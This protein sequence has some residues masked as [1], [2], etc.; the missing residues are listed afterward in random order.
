MRAKMRLKT[1]Q[2]FFMLI[3]LHLFLLFKQDNGLWVRYVYDWI[4]FTHFTKF[5]LTSFVQRFWLIDYEMNWNKIWISIL[6]TTIHY[7]FVT[8]YW[9]VQGEIVPNLLFSVNFF[10]WTLSSLITNIPPD[11]RCWQHKLPDYG[12]PNLQALQW[13]WAQ[14]SLQT[15]VQVLAWTLSPCRRLCCS[16]NNCN[17]RTSWCCS[18]VAS[19]LPSFSPA[20]T[21]CC[22]WTWARVNSRPNLNPQVPISRR[23]LMIPKWCRWLTVCLL[24]R[25]IYWS[26]HWW[27]RISSF[28]H[29][30]T[31]DFQ[32]P[33]CLFQLHFP[34]PHL[35]CRGTRDPRHRWYKRLIN[36]IQLLK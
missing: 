14:T 1:N 12:K 34:P 21:P 26:I 9:G 15:V 5:N 28:N 8:I 17:C 32:D 22:H 20:P 11:H 2:I 19:T 6:T 13:R 30:I 18:R 3:F 33:Q 7:Y 4:E 31:G 10:F 35:D 16:S 23:K 29:L 27:G 25:K 36:K 24:W